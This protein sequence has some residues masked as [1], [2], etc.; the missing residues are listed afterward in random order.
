MDFLKEIVIFLFANEQENFFLIQ[1]GWGDSR[2]GNVVSRR[3]IEKV[4]GKHSK[5]KDCY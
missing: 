3:K 2:Q 4:G 5:S 1:K